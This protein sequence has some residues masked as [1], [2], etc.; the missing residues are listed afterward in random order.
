M[1]LSRDELKAKID[2][3]RRRAVTPEESAAEAKLL[4]HRLREQLEPAL[5]RLGEL[6]V[7]YTRDERH[8][9]D[10]CEE[11]KSS[12]L[13]EIERVRGVLANTTRPAED[14][15]EEL[16]AFVSRLLKEF[17]DGIDAA[18]KAKNPGTGKFYRDQ[19]EGAQRATSLL[20][21]QLG[22][23][24]ELWE[25][26]R[27]SCAEMRATAREG[28]VLNLVRSLEDERNAAIE[29]EQRQRRDAVASQVESRQAELKAAGIET[30][31]NSPPRRLPC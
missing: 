22:G 10:A 9:A 30:E 6:R 31:Q 5:V 28:E 29:Q 23:M 25:N 20:T 8:I 16:K 2:E 17:R 4:R 3:I 19:L 24:P 26:D 21:S 15:C 12:L 1:L 14:I 7:N 11:T 18:E 13:K 27:R